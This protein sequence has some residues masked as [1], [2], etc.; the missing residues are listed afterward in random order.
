MTNKLS[1]SLLLLV[2]VFIKLF[3]YGAEVDTLA[4]F[5]KS[6]SKD[7]NVVVISPENKSSETPLLFLLHGYG[8]DEFAWLNIKPNL[9]DLVDQYGIT[10]VCPDGKNSWYW[11][12]PNI[13]TSLYETFVTKEL[14]PFVLNEYN[15]IK[16]KNYVAITGLSMGGHG[17]LWLASRYPDLF[18]A[19]GSTSGG[20]NLCEF[21]TNWNLTEHLG[22]Y[23][24]N[25]Q[26]W[27]DYT[28]MSH[29]DKLLA[30]N[31]ALIIDCGVDDF[32]YEVN[33]ELH[34]QLI[35]ADVKHDF[36]IRPGAHNREY[37]NNS[38][39]YQLLFFSSYFNSLKD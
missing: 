16:D 23:N 2:G 29:I 12:S 38:I 5:S 10:I 35:L 22:S 31:L 37:W 21:K 1:K 4:V 32:F 17:A 11:D 15:V 9:P 24:E 3:A 25:K 8:G 26:T 20:V 7:I 27:K 13:S 19:A 30:S 14:Y 36:I 33:K 39:E 6:M 18:G 28:V 34:R